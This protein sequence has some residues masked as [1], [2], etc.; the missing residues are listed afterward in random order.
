MDTRTVIDDPE[1]FVRPPED[2]LRMNAA[3]TGYS[4]D[5]QSAIDK[6]VL[7][8]KASL[9]IKVQRFMLEKMMRFLSESSV[10]DN[11]ELRNE[12]NAAS[13]DVLSM[14]LTEGYSVEKQEVIAKGNSY[15]AYVLVSIPKDHANHYL[16]EEIEQHELLNALLQASNAYLEIELNIRKTQDSNR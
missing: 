12:V 13:N 2:S 10:N 9:A 14:C 4:P 3:A 11:I 15:R 16:V 5:K 6:A 7:N 1:W 8:A